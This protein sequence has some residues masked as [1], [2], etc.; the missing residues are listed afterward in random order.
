[1][2]TIVD[3][4]MGNLR[5]VQKACEKVGAAARIVT[6]P[7]AIESADKLILPGV[8]AFRDAIAELR[9]L[10]LVAPLLSYIQADRPF[11]GICL[12]LQLLFDVSYED[13][14]WTGLGAFPGDVVRF[15]AD[16]ELKVPH[17]GWNTLEP[18]QPDNPLL[19]HLPADA[20]VY[21]VHSYYVR[22]QDDSLIAARTEYGLPFVSMIGRGNVFATQFHPEKSQK[23]GLQLLKNFADL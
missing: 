10:E 23:A 1:M 2:I 11:L 9:R 17:M 16:P 3:Y 20:S 7:A 6:D 4:G 5:S 22:P 21:F 14:E 18:A 19:R 13:G 12:G 8:G 15:P